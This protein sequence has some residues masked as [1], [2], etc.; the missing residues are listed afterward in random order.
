MGYRVKLVDRIVDK[1]KV[2]KEK[3]IKISPIEKI[4]D[5]DLIFLAVHINIL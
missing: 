4:N 3:G 1:K 5:V 2:L